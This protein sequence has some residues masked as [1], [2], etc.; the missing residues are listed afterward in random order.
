MHT[1]TVVWRNEGMVTVASRQ[2]LR[3]EIVSDPTILGG[4]PV[5]RGTRVPVEH[6]LAELR[7]GTSRA[8]IFRHYPS[9]PPDGVDA[10]L[11]W[12]RDRRSAPR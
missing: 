8:E 7:A 1:E 4:T 6:V 11:A 10:C 5:V 9:L 2:R 12:D 3:A